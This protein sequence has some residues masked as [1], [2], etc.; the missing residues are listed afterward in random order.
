[1]SSRVRENEQTLSELGEQ[2]SKVTLA[3]QELREENVRQSMGDYATWQDDS[4]VNECQKCEREFGLARRKVNYIVAPLVKSGLP[5]TNI[6]DYNTGDWRECQT[7]K[8][9]KKFSWSRAK[10]R[11]KKCQ[12]V[13]LFF[14]APLSFLRA[15]ILRFLQREQAPASIVCKTSKGVRRMLPRSSRKVLL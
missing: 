3:N 14:S 6:R 10:Y 2:L 11:S 9:N 15:D 13:L 1:M 8:Q 5:N 12:L 4:T 7:R